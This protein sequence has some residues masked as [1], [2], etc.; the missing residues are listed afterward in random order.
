MQLNVDVTIDQKDALGE[1]K[2]KIQGVARDL[3]G[4]ESG[5]LSDKGAKDV[6]LIMPTA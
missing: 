6:G 4:P 1:D 2:R 5:I 3:S